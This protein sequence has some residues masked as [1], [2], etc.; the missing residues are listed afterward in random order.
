[1]PRKQRS[2]MD[3]AYTELKRRIITLDLRPGERIDDQELSRELR[4]SRTPVREA[5]FL[6]AAEGWV[7]IRTRAGFIVRPLDI[8]DV[9]HVFEAHVVLARACARLAAIRVTDAELAVLLEA[10]AEVEA[11]IARRDFL[12]ITAANAR[13]HRLEAAATHSDVLRGMAESVHDKGQRLAYLCFGGSGATADLD[14]HFEL[15]TAQHRAMLGALSAHDPAAAQ[16]IAVEHVQLFL[17]RVQDYMASEVDVDSSDD[18]FAGIVL[19]AQRG[20][21]HAVAPPGARSAKGQPP[22]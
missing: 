14:G 10:E 11:A 6:L 2:L 17:Q 15:V 7:D 9:S 12:A 1:M 18:D 19:P 22:V 21:G 3:Q 13:L 4:F 20:R 16:R 8:T 5:I